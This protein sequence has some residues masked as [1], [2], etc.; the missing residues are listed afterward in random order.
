MPVLTGASFTA[1]FRREAFQSEKLSIL[2]PPPP[3]PAPPPP[4]LCSQRDAHHKESKLPPCETFEIFPFCFSILQSLK[5]TQRFK[6]EGRRESD[7]PKQ[8][9]CRRTRTCVLRP[10]FFF[11]L[12]NRFKHLRDSDT[13]H[14]FFF[15]FLVTQ[16]YRLI[17][18]T[19][20]KRGKKLRVF[21]ARLA[22]MKP[23][24]WLEEDG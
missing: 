12:W 19:V 20:E 1:S 7:P 5:V 10:L 9:L 21:V 23:R 15:L 22:L 6:L 14:F 2:N 16:A 17:E 11:V 13:L 24:R 3:T 4:V 18:R 8:L